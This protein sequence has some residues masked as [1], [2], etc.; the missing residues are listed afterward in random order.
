MLNP[1]GRRGHPRRID[2]ADRSVRIARMPM[3]DRQWLGVTVDPVT[4]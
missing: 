4:R 3:L 2:V 1:Q